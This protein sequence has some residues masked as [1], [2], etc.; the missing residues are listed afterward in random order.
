MTSTW[1]LREWLTLSL[2]LLCLVPMIS[3]AVALIA[4]AAIANLNL[5]SRQ[6]NTALWTKKL[7]AISVVGLGFGI[8]LNTAITLTQNNIGLILSSI[9]IT[10]V[11]GWGITRLLGLDKKTGYL[12]A[13][14]TAICGGSAIAATAPSINASNSQA[15]LALAVVFLLNTF[16][17]FV[18]P[19]FGHLLELT[20]M[21][22]GIWSAIAIHDTSSVVGA[23]SAYGDEALLVATTLKLARALWIVPLAFFSAWLFKSKDSQFKLP[24]FIGAYIAVL[25]FVHFVPQL[26]ELYSAIFFVAKRLLVVCLFFVG[27]GLSHEGLKRAGSKALLLGLSLWAIISGGSLFYIINS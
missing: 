18:F 3:S 5:H 25:I 2:A 1:K 12:I 27:F 19:F 16:A 9:V 22:F 4:G 21:Q 7:L 13:S 11:F 23:A 15:S 10:L 8:E 26:G 6:F 24:W 20:Q 17:L 14:G